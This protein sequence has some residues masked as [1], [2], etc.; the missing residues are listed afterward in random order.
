MYNLG[1]C[2][3]LLNVLHNSFNILKI[4]PLYILSQILKPTETEIPTSPAVT[5]VKQY[6]YSGNF[7]NDF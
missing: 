1:I 6:L 3:A 2:S 5:T 4:L 7:K